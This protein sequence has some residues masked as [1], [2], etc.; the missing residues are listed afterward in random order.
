[1]A[2]I[3]TSTWFYEFEYNGE[4]KR[5]HRFNHL[6]FDLAL[7]LDGANEASYASV[8]DELLQRDCGLSMSDFDFESMVSLMNELGEKVEGGLG[9]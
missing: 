6:P 7:K 2:N 5:I 1:M 8:L 4:K 9:E 3:D